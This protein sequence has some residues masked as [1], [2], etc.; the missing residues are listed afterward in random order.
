MSIEVCKLTSAPSLLLPSLARQREGSATRQTRPVS[1]LQAISAISAEVQSI[2]AMAGP[3][4]ASLESDKNLLRLDG[5]PR[6]RCCAASNRIL[7]SANFHWKWDIK[8]GWRTTVAPS[9]TPSR[10]PITWPGALAARMRTPSTCH[11]PARSLSQCSKVNGG[12]LSSNCPPAKLRHKLLLA[13]HLIS[14]P[15]VSHKS[16]SAFSQCHMMTGVCCAAASGCR[17]AMQYSGLA[18]YLTRPSSKSHSWCVNLAAAAV[19]T[20]DHT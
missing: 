7:P 11:C 3:S 9:A 20:E 1:L 17:T 16:D 19:K 4:E 14:G 18:A 13:R 2:K 12:P 6:Q 5:K 15:E 10:T 8:H